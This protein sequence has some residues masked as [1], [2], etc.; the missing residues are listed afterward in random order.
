MPIHELLDT[1]LNLLFTASLASCSTMLSHR[2]RQFY[3]TLSHLQGPTAHRSRHFIYSA[4]IICN[5]RSRTIEM[6]RY[7]TYVTNVIS[8]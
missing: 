3:H 4:R 2:G 1:T 8:S 7:I 6:L 5:D